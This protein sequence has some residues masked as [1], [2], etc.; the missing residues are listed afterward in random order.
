MGHRRLATWRFHKDV[1]DLESTFESKG[2]RVWCV[3][4]VGKSLKGAGVE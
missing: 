2:S 4:I 3:N 1:F